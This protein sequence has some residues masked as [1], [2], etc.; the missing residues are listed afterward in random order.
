MLAIAIDGVLRQPHSGAPIGTG[1][2]LYAALCEVANVALIAD[3]QTEEQAKHWLL[4]N[5]MTKH[6]Y[7][8]LPRETDP[9]D[10]GEQRVVQLT[11]LAE[12]GPVSMLVEADPAKAERVIR[13]GIP[14]LLNIHPAYARPEYLPGH[15][16]LPTPW[17][18]LLAEVD[19]QQSIKAND[20]RLSHEAV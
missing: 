18:S 8:V 12:H 1:N 7:L 13:E 14:V 11:R 3:S 5:D 17:S 15:K 10:G 4:V 6:N 2:L 19:R 20:D 9:E 16:S